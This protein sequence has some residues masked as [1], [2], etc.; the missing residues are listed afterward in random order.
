MTNTSL[1]VPF[2]DM[3]RVNSVC[4]DELLAKAQE[5]LLSGNY[6]LS[7]EVAG[8]ENEFAT[9]CGVQYCPGVGNGL[10]ALSLSLRAL[11]IGKGDEVIVP[12]H[13]FI[14]TWLA[15]NN[16]GATVV[17]VDVKP[18]T[19][20]LN[21]QL[22]EASISP[23][24]KAIMP[25]HLYGQCCEMDAI[26]SIAKKHNL[27]VIEDF[28][29]AQGALYNG[30]PAGSFGIINGTSFYPSKN[31]GAFGDAGAITTNEEALYKKVNVLRNYGSS[32]KYIHDSAG[33]NSR[34]DALQ[35][36]L[37]RI[38]LKYLQVENENRR[39]VAKK[40]RNALSGTGDLIF[41]QEATGTQCIYH[42]FVIRTQRRDALA[43]FLNEH[44]IGTMVH[45]PVPAFRQNA[46]SD[47]RLNPEN[48]PVADGIS[49][50]CLSLPM[51]GALTD[52]ETDFVIDGIINF[53]KS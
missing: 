34:L 3:A 25:V 22:I 42:L 23:R 9:F 6:I 39:R 13:T 35:A 38:K 12:A 47:L 27:Y 15:V 4:K 48:Y 24:T 16:A 7:N 29:Q 8:F 18:D 14:A 5:V 20:N 36:A 43:S 11:D 28:A 10:D 40:Y 51:F 32:Q 46:F 17:P 37:L 21:P 50:T 45:Y 19:C 52:A 26:L 33:C 49:K 1:K 2:Y 53:F 41:Q 31:L 30:K 44:G